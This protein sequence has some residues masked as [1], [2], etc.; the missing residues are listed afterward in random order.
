M[1]KHF[2]ARVN[3]CRDFTEIYDFCKQGI[4]VMKKIKGAA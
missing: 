2:I 4:V 3:I 1:K